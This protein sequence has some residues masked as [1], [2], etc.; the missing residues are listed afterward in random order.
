MF[1]QFNTMPKAATI[2]GDVIGYTEHEVASTI[3]Y[4]GF[5]FRR[6]RWVTA[7]FD[8][9]EIVA[10]SC[11]NLTEE[12]QQEMREK[13]PGSNVHLLKQP[14]NVNALSAQLQPFDSDGY[15]AKW[16]GVESSKGRL[17]GYH[18]QEKAVAVVLN[19]DD[20]LEH[21]LDWIAVDSSGFRARTLRKHYKFDLISPAIYGLLPEG[22]SYQVAETI[23]K[24]I[25]AFKAAEHRLLVP[26]DSIRIAEDTEVLL[27][28]GL[29]RIVREGDVYKLVNNIQELGSIIKR[30][31]GGWTVKLE[32]IH[33]QRD[34][35]AELAEGISALWS[36]KNQ[37]LGVSNFY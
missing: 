17:I 27:D 28:D 21:S 3:V 16:E 32:D 24:K 29:N 23:A 14:L 37:A 22:A 25:R 12:A 20:L 5:L 2:Y 31:E 34:N 26:V 15:H 36:C 1:E 33:C 9:S 4:Q 11:G 7:N 30:E 8:S 35:Y 19:S 10:F 18:N 13:F 6:G